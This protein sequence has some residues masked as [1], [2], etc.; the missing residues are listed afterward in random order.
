MPEACAEGFAELEQICS[1]PDMPLTPMSKS[2]FERALAATGLTIDGCEQAWH[3]DVVLIADATLVVDGVDEGFR[4]VPKHVR[5]PRVCN[6]WKCN[7]MSQ[8]AATWPYWSMHTKLEQSVW[9]FLSALNDYKTKG[10]VERGKQMD[11]LFAFASF[12][13]PAGNQYCVGCRFALR[14]LCLP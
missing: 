12:A 3:R 13:G 2:L 9:D 5:Y 11:T 1:G 14:R 8:Q 6:F 7:K 4:P 10:V